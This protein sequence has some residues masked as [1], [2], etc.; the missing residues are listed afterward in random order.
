MKFIILLMHD[1]SL[2]ETSK[3][4]VFKM[5]PF[6]GVSIVLYFIKILSGSRN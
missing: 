2:V 6:Y 5:F 1:Y 4:S 3:Q